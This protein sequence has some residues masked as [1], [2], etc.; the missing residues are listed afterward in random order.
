MVITEEN[1]KMYRDYYKKLKRI[2]REKDFLM[3]VMIIG[4]IAMFASIGILNMQIPLYMAALPI[5]G[6][7]LAKV[8]EIL[9]IYHLK[10]Q[11]E[12]KYPDFDRDVDMGDLEA[13]L[14]RSELGETLRKGLIGNLKIKEKP[15]ENGTFRFKTDEELDKFYASFDQE[16]IDE[17]HAK[18]KITPKEKVKEWESHGLCAPGDAI[19]SA[20]DR[21]RTF[22]NCNECLREFASYKDEH[23]KFEFVLD[24]SFMD[25]E[26][27]VKKHTF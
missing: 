25:E 9:S 13:S 17:I 4:G 10:N 16:K 12:K 20:S 27:V 8:Y 11:F 23:K 14:E 19:G 7:V 18:G 3:G 22:K 2:I 15:L 6:A 21:C 24:K 5:G 26:P 1:Y